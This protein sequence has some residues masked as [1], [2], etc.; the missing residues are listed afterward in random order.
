MGAT[1]W[2]DA[3]FSKGDTSFMYLATAM[4]QLMTPGLA[5]F[6]GGLC[7]SNSVVSIMFQSFICM[8]IIWCMW[9][10]CGFS[11]VFGEP[12]FSVS[13]AGVAYN[14]AA[15]PLTFWMWNGVSI[16]K[17]LERAGAVMV[18]GFPGM[19]FAAYQGMFAV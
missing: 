16:Y 7:G 4:V 14:L 2:R 8:G 18:P 11:M 15:N 9:I 13:V 5:L 3:Q 1:A 12:A 6:Y 19:L 10:V 17:P